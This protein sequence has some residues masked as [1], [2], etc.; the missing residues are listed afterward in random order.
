MKAVGFAATSI[1]FCLLGATSSQA[2][3]LYGNSA[4]GGNNPISII[5]ATTGQE[6]ARYIGQPSGNG[7]GV[8]TVGNTLYYTV[9][10]DSKIYEKDVATGNELG[11]IQTSNASMATLAW[12]GNDFWTSD[13]AGTNRAFQIDINGNNIKTI[14]LANASS[15]MDGLEYFNGKLIANRTDQGSIYDIYDLDGKV[16]TSNFINTNKSTTGIAYDGK[17]FYVSNIYESSVGIYD[18]ATGIFKSTLALKPKAIGDSFL[19]EDLS[20]DY[21][22]RQDTGGGTA[23]PEPFTIIGTLIGGTAAFRMRKKLKMVAK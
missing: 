5:D 14:N 8:V 3:N 10:N 1:S 18:G 2:I 9:T 13:Y 7:R 23:V 22:A 15:G 19:I 12:D 16:L 21:A 4:S 17:D 6:A 20:F 11:F